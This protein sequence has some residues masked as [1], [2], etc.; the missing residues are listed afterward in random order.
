FH[1]YKYYM[2]QWVLGKFFE[3]IVLINIVV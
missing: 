2:Q 3:K 1:I